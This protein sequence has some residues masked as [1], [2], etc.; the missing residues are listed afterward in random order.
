M[1][2]I[3]PPLFLHVLLIVVVLNGVMTCRVLETL[4]SDEVK[5]GMKEGRSDM[6]SRTATLLSDNLKNQFELPMLFYAAVLL[7]IA[8]QQPIADG[9]VTL[10]WVFVISRIIH[11]VIHTTVNIVLVRASVWGVGLLA[12]L[13]MWWHLFQQLMG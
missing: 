11:S 10:A 13:L 8:V 2:A 3:L 12:L 7:A 1:N 6:Y 5:K 9:F 4:K